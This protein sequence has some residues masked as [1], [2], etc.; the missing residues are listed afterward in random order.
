VI[1]EAIAVVTVALTGWLVARGPYVS[2]PPAPGRRSAG[3]HW[4]SSAELRVLSRRGPGRIALG[5]TTGR[6]RRRRLSTER[7]QSLAVIGPTQSGKTSALAVPAILDWD[8]PVLAASVKADL[9]G[10]TERWRGRLGTLWCLDPAGASGRPTN[11]W[12]PLRA[13]KTWPGARRVAADL[14]EV[15]RSTT[16]TA[17]GEF[18]YA[19]AAKLLAPLLFA[20]ATGGASLSDVVRWV[21]TQE[22]SEVLDCLE[23]AGVE[24]ALWSARASLGREERQ[25]SSVYTTAETVLEPLAAARAEGAEIDPEALLGGTNTLFLCAPAHD[26]RRLRGLFVAVVKEVLQSAFTRASRDGPLEPPLLVVLDEAANIAPVAE[27]DVLAA[28]CAGHGIALVTVWQDLAQVSARYGPRAPTVLNNHRARLFLPGI[29]E[30]STLEY[31]SMLVGEA[32][33]PIVPPAPPGRGRWPAAGSVERRRLLQPET[34]RQLRAGT[35]V[36]VYG[37]RPPAHVRLVPWWENPALAARG[38]GA[39]VL[40]R[41]R[42]HR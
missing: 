19:T 21:D 37:D 11:A 14:T 34:L 12:S 32:D 22:V 15:A 6:L 20:A 42:W 40:G 23:S 8:G 2:L 27:L 4:A 38:D 28:T 7:V 33:R 10:A 25:R 31:A 26:Q 13:A 39:P 18:W 35:A 3:A 1:G 29:A 41:R 24:E 16:T 17:D 5:T 30:P 9:L 36:L